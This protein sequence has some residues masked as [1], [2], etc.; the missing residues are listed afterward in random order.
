MKINRILIALFIATTFASCNCQQKQDK[1]VVEIISVE[2]FELVDN[3]IQL[4]DVRTPE[5]YA[6][7]HLKH[8]KNIDYYGDDFM[9]IMTVLNKDEA[10]YIYCRSGG[11]SGKAAIKLKEA[12]FTKIYDLGGGILQWKEEGKELTKE[13]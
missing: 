4:I 12:G 8:A 9:E 11:R 2:Q 3:T 6:E 13:E 1:K 10:L 7:G 5:E